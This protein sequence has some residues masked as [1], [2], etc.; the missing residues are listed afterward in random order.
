MSPQEKMSQLW[1]RVPRMLF[2]GRMRTTTVVMCV[3][4]LA[5]A[6]L[7]AYL[8]DQ[9]KTATDTS[10]RTGVDT[11]E[12]GDPV[13][14]K[15]PQNQTPKPSPSPETSTSST[16]PS[17]SETSRTEKQSGSATT[18]PSADRGTTTETETA[19][20]ST[21]TSKAPQ[22]TREQGATTSSA[23]TTTVPSPAG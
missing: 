5:L 1:G 18:T 16:P 23:E 6:I 2:G 4:W 20:Q 3:L 15:S 22:Q 7:N 21:T 12:F 17:Q 9:P 10:Q 14:D 19:E 11:S 13:P 8:N